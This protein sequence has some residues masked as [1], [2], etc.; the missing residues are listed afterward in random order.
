MTWGIPDLETI[1]KPWAVIKHGVLDKFPD[2]FFHIQTLGF[3][4]HV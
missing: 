2:F 3:P 1:P 4:S